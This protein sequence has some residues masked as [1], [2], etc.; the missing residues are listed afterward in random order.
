MLIGK[1]VLLRPIEK[2]FDIDLFLCWFNDAEVIRGLSI[3]LP[4][5]REREIEWIKTTN[6][7]TSN[8]VLAI[9]LQRNARSKITIGVCGLHNINP[10]DRNAVFGITIGAKEHWGKGYGTEAAKLMIAYGFDY[11]NLHRISSSVID[12]NESSI[13][14]HDKLGFTKEGRRKEVFFKNG[15]YQDEITF[16]IVRS[17]WKKIQ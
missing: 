17:D 14:M 7:S 9:E 12:S 3:P 11:L 16:G 13:R 15:Q 8:I 10:K 6:L 1:N 5:T 4:V 2:E